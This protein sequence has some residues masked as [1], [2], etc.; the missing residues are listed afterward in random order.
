MSVEMALYRHVVREKIVGSKEI[1]D[2][3]KTSLFG[4]PECNGHPPSSPDNWVPADF[5]GYQIAKLLRVTDEDFK[6]K[7]GS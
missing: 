3:K 2:V 7:R 6:K 5:L 4:Y 1:P